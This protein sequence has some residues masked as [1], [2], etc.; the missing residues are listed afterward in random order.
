MVVINGCQNYF[1]TYSN[2][3]IGLA[4]F[5]Q[6]HS[7]TVF[8]EQAILDTMQQISIF[9]LIHRLSGSEAFKALNSIENYND[10]GF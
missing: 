2:S 10:V 1:I 4:L 6:H 3:L 7:N 9:F 8:S 5:L